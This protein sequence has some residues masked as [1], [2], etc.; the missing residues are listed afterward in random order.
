MIQAL[1]KRG[2]Y[3]P[4][5]Q[6]E[7]D[8]NGVEECY[9]EGD[10]DDDYE[11]SATEA[12]SDRRLVQY[13][14][15]RDRSRSRVSSRHVPSSRGRSGGRSGSRS[16]VSSRHTRHKC[17]RCRQWFEFKEDLEVHE[18]ENDSGCMRCGTFFPKADAYEHARNARNDRCFVDDCND[19]YARLGAWP[20]REIEEHVWNSH[21]SG[22]KVS[23]RRHVP[24]RG[25]QESVRTGRVRNAT[26]D[27]RDYHAKPS[28]QRS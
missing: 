24:E 21:C 8:D 22:S 28:R 7:E 11:T 19:K 26:V 17:D 10:F 18:E 25:R 13:E 16:R 20:D 1:Q 12:D 5:E 14:E 2:E 3:E 23:Q 15:D 27:E 4:Y 6:Y 9:D